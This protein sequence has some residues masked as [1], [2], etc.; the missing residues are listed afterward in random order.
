MDVHNI[1]EQFQQTEKNSNCWAGTS[2]SQGGIQWREL[3]GCSSA[4]L[5]LPS[6]SSSWHQVS[7]WWKS[8]QHLIWSHLLSQV[9][10]STWTILQPQDWKQRTTQ[11]GTLTFL[12]SPFVQI[13]RW[14]CISEKSYFH[15]WQ[16]ASSSRHWQIQ[17]SLGQNCWRMQMPPWHWKLRWQFFVDY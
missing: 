3:F 17:V 6:P 16:R 7:H 5:G 15:S 8:T 11:F 2:P 12:G 9:W 14:K 4:S 1:T 10:R 13:P